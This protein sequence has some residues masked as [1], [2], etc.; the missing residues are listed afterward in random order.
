MNTTRETC[1]VIMPFSETSP[2]HTEEYWTKHFETFLKPL[3]EANPNLEARQSQALRG[4]ILRGIITDLVVSRV[5]LAD[6]TDHNPNVFW[7]LGV[8]QSFKHGTVTIAEVDTKL[9]F[10][11]SGKGTL[12]YYPKDH[13]KMGEFRKSFGEAIQDYLKNPDNPDSHVLETLSG[14]GT[15]FEIFRKDEA[16]RRLNALVSEVER[17]VK[18]FGDAVR[19]AQENKDNPGLGKSFRG[20][21]RYSAVELLMTN[22]YIEE[23][24]AFFDL[25]G[26]YFD[27]VIRI[28]EQLRIWESSP[29]GEGK[30][31]Q[32]Y[33]LVNKDTWQGAMK[34]FKERVEG[35]CTGLGK[36]L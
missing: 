16:L 35:I 32:E 5:V 29:L 17:N 2:E 23:E 26:T 24:E 22:R 7:E 36:R 9:P 14:R 6:L 10:D 21:L 18:P 33:I 20:R 34:I 11:V 30:T 27:W 13:L 28:N 3:I 1:F 4:D 8:R 15:L 31:A 19:I 25:A 12:F